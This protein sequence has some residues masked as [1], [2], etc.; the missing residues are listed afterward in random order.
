MQNGKGTSA[1]HVLGFSQDVK[2]KLGL[3]PTAKLPPSGMANR[4]L[5]SPFGL[6]AV[7]VAAIDPNR[8][9]GQ[10]KH[11]VL[12][13]CPVCTKE[14]SLGRLHQHMVVHPFENAQAAIERDW[15]SIDTSVE[16]N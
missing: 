9:R 6:V 7:R 12:A 14:L 1:R 10:K 15:K 3:E 16:E 5:K 8:R 13:I 11:R 4:L 2:R